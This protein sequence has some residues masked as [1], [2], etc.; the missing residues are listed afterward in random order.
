M[1][2]YEYE[3]NACGHRH[4]TLQK[5]SDDPLT[6]CPECK[7]PKL[8]KLMSAAAFRLKGS[9]WY[10]TDFKKGDKKNL[11]QSDEKSGKKETASD[12][13]T[14]KKEKKEKKDKKPA[15]SDS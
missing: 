5:M 6:D 1:P 8:K 2:I 7:E 15:R 14:D 4:E 13:K 3:C 11:A 10:E 9:G 12:K